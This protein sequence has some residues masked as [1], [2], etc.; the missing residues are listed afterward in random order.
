MVI[1]NDVKPEWLSVVRRLQSVG[2]SRGY[3]VLT[4]RVLV[5]AQGVPVLWMEPEQKKLEP[6]PKTELDEGK[7]LEML[8]DANVA[9]QIMEILTRPL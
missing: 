7:F 2:T 4:I 5:N 9:K 8:K 3:S 6:W 1:P